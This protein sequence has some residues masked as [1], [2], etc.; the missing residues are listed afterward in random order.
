M[1]S[2]FMLVYMHTVLC[3]AG[4]YYSVTFDECR[5]CSANN[6]TED[7]DEDLDCTTPSRELQKL[8]LNLPYQP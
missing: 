8:F 4:E 2:I 3:E 1:G 5:A 6:G 7:L